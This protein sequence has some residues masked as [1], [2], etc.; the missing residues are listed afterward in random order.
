LNGGVGI[1][2]KWLEVREVGFLQEIVTDINLTVFKKP[3]P[4]INVFSCE[5]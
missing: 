4:L 5:I 1:N 2:L 3:E